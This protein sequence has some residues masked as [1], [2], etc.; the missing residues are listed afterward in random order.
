MLSSHAFSSKTD[1]FVSRVAVSVLI[2]V[3]VVA[4]VVV[5]TSSV[6]VDVAIDGVASVA[7]VDFVV[8]VVS[9]PAL[10]KFI[11]VKL[12]GKKDST[13]LRAMRKITNWIIFIFF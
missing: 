12:K 8:N 4:S 6:L 7:V 11:C 13:M 10:K 5:F 3:A 9:C 1:F 2:A